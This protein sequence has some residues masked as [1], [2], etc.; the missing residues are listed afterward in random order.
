MYDR[1][2]DNDGVNLI[3]DYFDDVLY[4]LEHENMVGEIIDTKIVV[5]KPMT[6]EKIGKLERASLLNELKAN[7]KLSNEHKNEKGFKKRWRRII[8]YIPW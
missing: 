2:M 6:K 4:D 5:E 8:E 7:V 3:N 1:F